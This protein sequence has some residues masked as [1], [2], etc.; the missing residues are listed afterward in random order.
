MPLRITDTGLWSRP[1][2]WSGFR[3][4]P[5]SEVGEECRYSTSESFPR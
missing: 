4:S 3:K 1:G 2:I 5:A